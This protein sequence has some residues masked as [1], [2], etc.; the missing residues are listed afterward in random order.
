MTDSILYT[1]AE[2]VAQIT[3]NRPD[4][5]NALNTDMLRGLKTAFKQAAKDDTVRAVLLTG[6]GKGFC[7]GQDLTEFTT[8]EQTVG[9]HLRNEYNGLIQQMR[10]LPKP[11]VCAVNGVAAGAGASLTLGADLRVASDESSFVFGAFVSIGLVADSGATYLL[12]QIIGAGRAMEL[13][14]LNDGKHRLG[15]KQA[16]DWGLVNRLCEADALHATAANIAQRLATMPTAA[17]GLTKRAVY[18]NMQRGLADA[19][20][21]EAH[22]QDIAARTDDHQ[23]GV[24]AFLEKRPPTFNGR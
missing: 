15:G 4:K 11:I 2:G 10:T 6:A 20:E 17:I 3:L 7:S 12:P 19:L 18:G 5:Y 23:E 14:L 8:S 21:Y 9:D 22:I 24:N 1:V 16:Y 13:F